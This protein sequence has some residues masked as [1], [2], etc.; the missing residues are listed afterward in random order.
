M[1]PT[2]AIEMREPVRT[3]DVQAGTFTYT[4]SSGNSVARPFFVRTVAANETGLDAGHRSGIRQS[5]LNQQLGD[6]WEMLI[7]SGNT[8]IHYADVRPNPFF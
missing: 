3:A 7:E 6:A 4:D 2:N 1:I 5:D 8:G